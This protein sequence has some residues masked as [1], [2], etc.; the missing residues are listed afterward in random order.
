MTSRN[1]TDKTTAKIAMSICT[2]YNS[3]FSVIVPPS[4]YDKLT[5]T[6]SIVQEEVIGP[7]SVDSIQIF[8][9]TKSDSSTPPS[10]ELNILN[11]Y[12]RRIA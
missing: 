4:A 1:I 12:I 10:T 5:Y 9:K 8:A 3:D 6:E 2:S 11:Y 7:Q